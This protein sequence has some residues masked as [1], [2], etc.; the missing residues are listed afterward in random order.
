[1]HAKYVVVDNPGQRQPVKHGVARL[2]D[3]FAE[4]VAEAVLRGHE[5]NGSRRVKATAPA[6]AQTHASKGARCVIV[7]FFFI[8]KNSRFCRKK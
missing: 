7:R 5:T 4:G 8:K 1:M 6:H 2:P 3:F